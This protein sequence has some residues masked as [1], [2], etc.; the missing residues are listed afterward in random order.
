MAGQVM[1]QVNQFLY[2]VINKAMAVTLLSYQLKAR[3]DH[4]F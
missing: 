3:R 1:A 2:V 4:V